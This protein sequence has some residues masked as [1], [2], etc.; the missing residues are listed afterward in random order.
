MPDHRNRP[1]YE[2]AHGGGVDL[3]KVD[4]PWVCD[5]LDYGLE[6]KPNGIGECATCRRPVYDE[7]GIRI[8]NRRTEKS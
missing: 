7:H 1:R 5:C 2:W 8:M 6:P 3:R 4:G